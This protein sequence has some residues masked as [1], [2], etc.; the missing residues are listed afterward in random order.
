[1]KHIGI[2]VPS[3]HIPSETFVVTEINALVKAGHKV[4]VVTFEN[5]NSSANL[6][7]SVNV[8]IIKKSFSAAA[9]FAM[10]KPLVAL[11]AAK[12]AFRFTSI[13]AMSLL[14]YGLNIA[15]I[16]KRHGISHIHC[17]FMHAPL[18][19][20]I[21]ARKI[22]GISVSSIGHGHDV[23]VN[24]TDLKLKLSLCDFSVAVCKDMA[25]KLSNYKVGKV[26]LLHCGVD[27]SLF[28]STPN[29]LNESVKLLFIGRLVE[30]KGLQFLLPAIKKLSKKYAIC[31]DI[32]G[33]G[34][35]MN[36]LKFLC[37][38]LGLD[39]DVRFLGRRTPLWLSKNTSNYSALVAPFCVSS[40]GDRDTW[41]VVLKEAMASGIPV[42]TTK[43]MGAKEIVNDSVGFKCEPSSIIGLETILTQFC[44]LN[45]YERYAKGINAKRLVANK[46]NASSQAKKL[47][48]WVQN[49]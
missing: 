14:G 9:K 15:E 19:Y 47:S 27:L 18:A 17:H 41:P 26:E 36:D 45:P 13:S 32:V 40:N 25:Q 11:N 10:S 48:S 4:S 23:Y 3:F 6:D 20:S 30:K 12:I 24:D 31:L 38:E 49:S 1:M 34:P 33:E 39:K 16:I 28:S 29:R 22:A 44:E 43:L 37:E 5:L 42:L 2:V 8:I 7:S 46:F 35:L 21:V